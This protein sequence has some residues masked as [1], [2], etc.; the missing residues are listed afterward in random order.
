M[1]FVLFFVIVL[2]GS[3]GNHAYKETLDSADACHARGEA[4]IAALKANNKVSQAE[5][6]C[7]PEADFNDKVGE[8]AGE[9]TEG[10]PADLAPAP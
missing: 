3:T 7:L 6:I 8:H 5:G 2:A 1:K 10:I 9:V 4:V